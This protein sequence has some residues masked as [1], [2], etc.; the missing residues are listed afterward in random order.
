[1]RKSF[2]VQ[3]IKELQPW[4]EVR[5]IGIMFINQYLEVYYWR[6]G[7][8]YSE[9]CLRFQV[10]PLLL[11]EQPNE[12]ENASDD[13]DVSDDDLQMVFLL[14]N[15]LNHSKSTLTFLQSVHK[16]QKLKVDQLTVYYEL[17]I[18]NLLKLLARNL[19]D[20]ERARETVNIFET[21]IMELNARIPEVKKIATHLEYN[22]FVSDDTQ[23]TT[24]TPGP[25]S[26]PVT[27]STPD[28]TCT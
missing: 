12:G 10:P 27:I 9:K 19:G 4:I 23:V 21:Q 8:G 7:N 14:Q 18:H 20:E 25:I 11:V 6:I 13:E 16:R 24:S 17:K 3:Q 5:N 15:K 26:I 2:L 28:T 22:Y 1:K